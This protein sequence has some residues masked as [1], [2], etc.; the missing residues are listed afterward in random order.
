[1][2]N[3]YSAIVATTP[4]II[5]YSIFLFTSYL[6]PNQKLPRSARPRAGIRRIRGTGGPSDRIGNHVLPRPNPDRSPL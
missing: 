4:N 3:V 2:I 5:R 1:M 6:S